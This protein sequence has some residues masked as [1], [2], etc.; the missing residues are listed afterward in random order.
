[1]CIRDRGDIADNAKAVC[2]N[3]KF[4]GIAEMA[5]DIHLLNVGIGGGMWRHRT[6]GGSVGVVRV[7]QTLRLLER[8]ELFNDLIFVLGIVFLHPCFNTG[9]IE[10]RCV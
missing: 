3:A 7:I 6:I 2:N 5:I 1:M 9:G 8:L 10:K 4:I